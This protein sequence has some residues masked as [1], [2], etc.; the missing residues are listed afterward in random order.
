V[1]R[2]DDE[3]GNI[4]LAIIVLTQIGLLLIIAKPGYSPFRYIW[5]TFPKHFSPG[6]LPPDGAGLNPLLQNPWMII[7]PP[8]LFIGYASATIPFAYAISGLLKN[9]YSSWI[10][11]SYRWVLFSMTSLGIGIFLG[12][13]WAYTVLGWGG[14]WGWDPVENSSLIPWLVIVAL[15]HGLLLQ[16]RKKVLVKT[17]IFLALLSLIL[18]FYSTFLTRSG[19]L[20]DFSVHSFG[21]LGSSGNLIFFIIF[22][23]IISVFLFIKRIRDMIS[24]PLGEKIFTVENIICFGILA[25]C[26]YSLFILIGTSMPI[27]SG[28]FLP[29]FI[30]SFWNLYSY[31]YTSFNS[32]NDL[33]KD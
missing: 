31:I 32:I 23:I 20:S 11:R 30:N 14:Y 33:K 24:E 3:Y 8:V 27:L 16:K 4:I 22:F 5:D 12:A 2:S 9:D 7:H 13:Y 15:M 10:D 6:F 21:D 29:K 17:N 19:V 25:L 28:I 26:F 18:V 1:I